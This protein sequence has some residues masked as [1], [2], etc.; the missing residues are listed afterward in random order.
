MLVSSIIRACELGTVVG[1][2]TSQLK[3]AKM[4]FIP[5]P[6]SLDCI[7]Y[8][9]GV[10]QAKVESFTYTETCKS[11]VVTQVKSCFASAVGTLSPLSHPETFGIVRLKI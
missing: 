3:Q 10:P 6:L 2:G 1:K 5:T 11:L 9:A 7:L 4:A 8:W